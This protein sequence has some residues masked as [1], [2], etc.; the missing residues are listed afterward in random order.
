MKSIDDNEG[1]SDAMT[2]ESRGRI[3]IKTVRQPRKKKLKLECISAA[4]DASLE[5]EQKQKVERRKGKSALETA[6]ATG[7]AA[8]GVDK[9]DTEKDLYNNQWQ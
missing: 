7:A 4:E 6:A 2:Y 9:G 8:I 1:V 3:K 5:Y